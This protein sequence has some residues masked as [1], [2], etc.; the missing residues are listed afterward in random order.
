MTLK[1]YLSQAKNISYR[2]KA[3]QAINNHATADQLT[4]LSNDVQSLIYQLQDNILIAT[5][6][7]IY[8]T[9]KSYEQIAELTDCTT[10]TVSNRHEQ[11]LKK[12][13]VIYNGRN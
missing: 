9:D 6:E 11:A 8:F 7:Y 3:E 5:M 13:E 10:R 4:Q 2:I 1:T 12:L